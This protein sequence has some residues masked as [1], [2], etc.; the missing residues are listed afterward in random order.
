MI[1]SGIKLPVDH[2][3]HD[4]ELRIQKKYGSKKF[5]YKI[6]KK[7]IDARYADVSFVYNVEVIDDKDDFNKKCDL[8]IDKSDFKKRPVVVGSG[9]CGLFAAYV[10]AKSGACPIVLERGKAV[11]ERL[12]DIDN[13]KLNRV[14]NT[15]SNIQFGEGGAGTFSDGK[16]T[17][18]INNP[19][20]EEVLRVFCKCGAP[21]EI[22]YLSKPHLGTDNLI[23]IVKKLREH[24]IELGGEFHFSEK[25][26]DIIIENNSVIKAIGDKEYET[27]TVILAL[28]HSAR[29]T[30]S[31]LY[32]KGLDII[33]KA[34]SVGARIEHPQI[35]VNKCQYGKFCDYPQLGAAD[36]KISY[37]TSSGRG[38]Y[39][40]CMC[41][42][43]EVVAAQ[44]E[45]NSVVTN[46][47]SYYSRNEKNAN[48][49]FLVGVGPNDFGNN[50]FDG[51]KFQ[52]ELEKKA[53]VAGGSNYN[54]PC[55]R[56]ED[57]INKVPSKS[58][59][60]VE[61]SYKPGVTLTDLNT[62]LPSFVTDTMRE[63]I[64]YFSK[65]LKFFD[66]K[67]SLLTGVETRS[68]SPVRICRDETCQAKYI[69]L[70]PAGEGA[71][72]AGG[73]MSAAV[74]GIKVALAAID[75]NKKNRG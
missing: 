42:G 11:D 51:I 38:A 72:Y 44:S 33:A 53:F 69:G 26:R 24:I 16:L 71:G 13:F 65:K 68:S 27:D 59:G 3:I 6:I 48:S 28:G 12:K 2:S 9:P 22:M 55:Q 15:T 10:L 43:G 47:M 32:D 64:P 18:Q 50:P 63:A 17:T 8:I 25:L 62:V 40:F 30:F 60:I 34:F 41:P 14:L 54:A 36:Y 7:S 49:A 58:F 23:N 20:C 46:G 37:H 67:D 35:E 45:E 73:I 52:M 75:N 29:D 66:M 1:I 57:F 39:T 4:L 56:L 70:Y 74:D 61:P 5:K 19:L 21:E 31:M